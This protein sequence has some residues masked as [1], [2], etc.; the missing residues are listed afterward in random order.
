MAA[1]FAAGAV[2]AA[3]IY[4]ALA[5]DRAEQAAATALAGALLDANRE[6]MKLIGPDGRMLRISEY[7]AGLMDAESPAQLAGAQWLSFWTGAD[8]VAASTAF[9]GVLAGQR[10][11][12]SGLAHTTTGRPKWWDTRL[13][14]VKDDTGRVV[15]VLGASLD[16]TSRSNLLAQLQAKNE[17]MSE[18]E[19]HMPLVLYSYSADFQVFHYISAGCSAVFGLE[20]AQLQRNASAWMERVLAEDLEALRGEMDR[21]VND[22]VEGRAEYRFIRNMVRT[23]RR[24]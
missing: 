9:A 16:V 22:G 8:S 7:G 19:A 18:T 10:T 2:L 20:P 1:G 17:L 23:T 24:C 15:A 6:C 14:S 3:W 13:T 5:A 11:S 4:R 12:F 21:I